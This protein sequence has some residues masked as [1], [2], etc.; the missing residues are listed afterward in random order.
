LGGERGG[1]KT[2]LQKIPACGSLPIEHLA[3]GEDA[4]EFSEHQGGIDF[5]PRESACGRDG[6]GNGAWSLEF[7]G[8][9]LEG[10]GESGSGGQSLW[11][12]LP[13]QE[14]GGSGAEAP[15]ANG[16][17]QERAPSGTKFGEEA[18]GGEVGFEVEVEEGRGLGPEGGAELVEESAFQSVARDE[19]FSASPG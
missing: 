7:E 3:C 2:A 10:F 15:T 13:L 5:A 9:R 4:R 11:G 19:Q 18:F 1:S 6:L 12:S 16:L 17:G 8:E 14:S